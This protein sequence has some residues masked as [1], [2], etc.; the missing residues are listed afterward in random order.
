MRP[1]HRPRLLAAS[2]LACVAAALSLACAARADGDPASDVLVAESVFLPTDVPATTAQRA[3]LDQILQ[4]LRARGLPVK[5]ALIGSQ[6]DLGSVAVLWRQPD[7]YARFLGTELAL[8][9]KG[10]LLVVMPDG[11]G[12]SRGGKSVPADEAAVASAHPQGGLV[13]AAVTALR[14][15]A[16][17]HGVTLPA[18]VGNPTPAP[19][20]SHSNAWLTVTALVAGLLLVAAGWAYS[21]R[22]RPLRRNA[23][24]RRRGRDT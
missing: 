21:L 5:V 4:A 9:Y 17:A 22:V 18:L 13:P 20:R 10:R 2:L 15:L 23:A 19:A 14:L 3:A 16:R 1:H 6:Y 12:V 8:L 24:A 11:I 7:R